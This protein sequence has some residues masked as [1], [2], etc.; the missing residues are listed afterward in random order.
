[1][2]PRFMI[3]SGPTLKGSNACP[4][5]T[6]KSTFSGS[7]VLDAMPRDGRA[8]FDQIAGKLKVQPGM[9]RQRDPGWA[10]P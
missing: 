1:M 7:H 5:L 10:S 8:A 3:S 4:T 9:I 2:R 6:G